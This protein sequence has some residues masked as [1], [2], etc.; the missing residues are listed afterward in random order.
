MSYLVIVEN[1]VTYLSLPIRTGGA[2]AVDRWR[3]RGLLGRS[4][5]ARA[6][7]PGWAARGDSTS[8]VGA[9]GRGDAAGSSGALGARAETDGNRAEQA[10]Y[11]GGCRLCGAR[12]DYWGPRVRLE[13]ERIDWSWALDRLS[14]R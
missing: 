13:Q 4:G 1:E 8:A 7:D 12:R 5:H 14:T 2:T 3:A 11:G 6:R 10:W 9:D